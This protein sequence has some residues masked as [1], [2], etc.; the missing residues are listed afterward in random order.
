MDGSTGQEKFGWVAPGA[1][2]GNYVYAGS[3]ITEPDSTEAA[4]DEDGF[5]IPTASG[6]YKLIHHYSQKF[7]LTYDAN[8]GTF[9]D[10]RTKRR[11]ACPAA[12]IR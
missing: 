1:A 4:V 5:Y 8:G 12:A 7:D 6:E 11:L 9:A 10:D 2:A 3:T